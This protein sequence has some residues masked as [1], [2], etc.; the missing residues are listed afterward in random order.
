LAQK[1]G[2]AQVEPNKVR[3]VIGFGS[4][5]R[6]RYLGNNGSSAPNSKEQN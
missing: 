3:Q 6:D 5:L 2:A 1:V 4:R